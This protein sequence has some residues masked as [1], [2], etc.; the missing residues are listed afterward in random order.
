MTSPGSSVITWLT[1]STTR[2][3]GKI[4]SRVLDACRV[5]PLT[6][7]PT[8]SPAQSSPTA[9]AGPTGAN[10]SKPF[11]RVYCTSRFWRSRS[12]TSLTHVSPST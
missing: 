11:A 9:I 2:S 3:G 10:V 12:V 4:I 5:S 8:A 1:N 7:E 6:V